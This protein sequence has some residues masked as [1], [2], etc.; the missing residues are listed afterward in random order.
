MT[1]AT[2]IR[3]WPDTA[4]TVIACDESGNEG[5]RVADASH[6]VFSHAAVAVPLGE[7]QRIIV[8]VRKRLKTQ[9]AELK[10]KQ[11]LQPRARRTMRWLFGSDGPLIGRATTYLVEK[12]YFGSSKVIDELYEEWTHDHGIELHVN[13]VARDIA[14][15][16]YR[17]GPRAFARADWDRLLESFNSLVRVNHRKGTQTTVDEFFDLL[18]ELKYKCRRR[19]VEDVMEILAE[20][21]EY[22]EFLIN[23]FDDP[24]ASPTMDP[25]FAAL[26]ATI[27]Y[28]YELTGRPVRVVHDVQSTLTPPR[29]SSMLTTLQSTHDFSY[30]APPI[31]I[32]G[33]D[34]AD[35]RLDARVQLADLLAGASR[36]VA[37]DVWLGKS[38]DGLAPEIFAPYIVP[39]SLW[40][41]EAS[42]NQLTG[43]KLA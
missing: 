21:R 9:A 28:W 29:L 8:E 43:S 26:P 16:F 22:A 40:A 38:L 35:S 32:A 33:F 10:S 3:A 5:D 31:R 42:W 37:S 12:S 4:I 34:F 14:W 27:M 23:H 19:W 15:K 13:M 30:N 20:C 11:L 25:L 39:R 36:S 18:D 1:G 41:D 6:P 24:E 2:P 17:L 7:A